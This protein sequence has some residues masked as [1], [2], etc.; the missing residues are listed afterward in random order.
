MKKLPTSEEFNKAL[1]ENIAAVTFTGLILFG[2]AA[3]IIGD[4]EEGASSP[5]TS[6]SVRRVLDQP[7]RETLFDIEVRKIEA[8]KVEDEIDEETQ[9]V[10]DEAHAEMESWEARQEYLRRKAKIQQL[11]FEIAE[12]KE[13]ERQAEIERKMRH[14]QYVAETQAQAI[15]RAAEIAAQ[16]KREAVWVQAQA[17]A[18]AA[19]EMSYATRLNAELQA[20]AMD[21][22]AA[23]ARADRAAQTDAI[24]N[25]TGVIGDGLGDVSAAIWSQ[26]RWR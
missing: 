10:A 17:T 22:A 16:A 1:A 7:I 13:R 18:I 2:C 6:P 25:Q 4:Y 12:A 9:L 5:S 20:R 11:E 21:N 8:E 23:M 14:E 24:N 26:D 19:D 3:G 15:E